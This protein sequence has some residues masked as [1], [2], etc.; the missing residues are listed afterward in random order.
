MIPMTSNRMFKA[1]SHAKPTLLARSIRLLARSR[2]RGSTRLTYVLAN[3][4]GSLQ[5]VPLNIPGWMPVYVDLR[6]S[7]AHFM[8]M[9]SPFKG[10]WRELE[11]VEIMHRFV[12]EGDVAFDIGANVGLHSIVLS[13][14]VGPTGKLC[15]FE[16]NPELLHALK[17]TIEQL[18]NATLYN[19]ALSN[20][21][22]ESQLFVPPDNTVASLTD[23]TI[24]SPIFNQDGPS[25][26]VTCSER[27]LDDL[28][29]DGTL[30]QPDFIKCDVEGAELRVFE[31]SA[32]TLSRVDA[33]II[34]FEANE[35]ASRGFN[36]EVSAAKDFLASLKGPDYRFYELHEGGRL[37][38]IENVKPGFSNILAVP[39]SK[40]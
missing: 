36:V 5:R 11:E 35:C 30:P 12:R 2:V 22:A 31:G 40:C 33:P 13:R 10:L 23:W 16:P 21:D 19:I 38:A 7:N 8:L 4:F 1:P 32:G 20:K 24:A 37:L 3:H 39:K 9:E 29:E 15:S 18:G 27:R 17:F 14:L 6:L 34:L 26:V 25:H 28:I